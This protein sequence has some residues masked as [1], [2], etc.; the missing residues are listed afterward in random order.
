MRV[1]LLLLFF[2]AVYSFYPHA[3][4][5]GMRK[6][7][8][9]PCSSSVL[10]LTTRVINNDKYETAIEDDGY[11]L[12]QSLTNRIKNLCPQWLLP[13]ENPG[14]LILIRHGESEWNFNKTFTGWVDVDLSARG[15]IEIQH[16]ARLLLERGYFVDVVYTSRLKRA[17]R[18]TWI[19]LKELNQIYKAVYKSWRLNERMYGSIE[20]LS[21]PGLAAEIGEEA[22]QAFRAGL[23]TRPPAMTPD[24]HYFHGKERKYADLTEDEIPLTESLQDTMERSLPLFNKK[25]LP[26]LR[27]GQNVLIVAHGNSLRGIVKHIDGLTADEIQHVG[28]PNGIPLIYKFDK[29]MR[30]IKQ[31]DAEGPLSG[32]FLEKKGL[33]RNALQREAEHYRFVPGYDHDKYS[34]SNTNA[35]TIVTTLSELEKKRKF[36]DGEN[37]S[38]DRGI[39]S[40]TEEQKR[41]TSVNLTGD[42]SI[43]L[44]TYSGFP[45][46]VDSFYIPSPRTKSTIAKTDSIFELYKPL[47]SST[48]TGPVIVIIRHGKTEFNKLGLFT[49]WEDAP[50]A[51]EG[52]E[53][54]KNAGLLLKAHGIE[55][56]IVYTSWLSR[57]IETAWLVL[58][59]LDSL[60]LPILKTWRLN[61]R[62]YG[63]LTGLS[64]K[65]IK[66]RHGEVQ[67]NKWRRGYT[68][69]PP[70]ISSFSSDYP[71]NDERYV[72]YVKDIRASL[73][74]SII[75]SLAHR[76]FEIHRKFPK[77]ESLKDCMD[78]TIPYFRDVIVPGSIA[79]NK[80]VLIA[81]SENAIRGLLMHLC[82]IPENRISEVEIPT[83]L[84]LVYDVK[85]KCIRL[86][87]DGSDT[88]PLE[89]YNFGKGGKE[90][91]FKSCEITDEDMPILETEGR[92]ESDSKVD[93][94]DAGILSEEV[95][96]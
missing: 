94:V 11:N 20:G 69:R 93:K 51:P 14:T 84:P 49:G 73:S 57:A 15:K 19:L 6:V 29:R 76:K 96:A 39:N 58:D 90:L 82:E 5:V 43:P 47:N 62:M 48:S 9:S 50:L 28:I 41:T 72:S 74:E 59:E 56:D 34:T 78:R 65:M 25:I 31:T 71:G 4:R 30:P 42:A 10:F 40:G 24:H 83:G 68:N 63:A 70:P 77:T 80:N 27:D 16:A 37:T 22:V 89:K 1:D 52:R 23:M 7:K 38:K 13:S 66:Q 21:K 55:F 2:P 79:K 53:E 44:D 67:F 54:A 95:I 26:A 61:E 92:K 88:D 36:F 87:D 12:A 75:R 33:L 3:P 86:L 45:T 17:I 18:S 64:K 8:S 32:E 46:T 91:L 85:R 60:W 35:G 81:S